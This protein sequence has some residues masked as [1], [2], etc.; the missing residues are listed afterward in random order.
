MDQDRCKFSMGG[1]I[2]FLFWLFVSMFTFPAWAKTA[3]RLEAKAGDSEMI[4]PGIVVEE[5][6]TNPS[7][8]KPMLQEGDI[9][10]S[11]SRGDAHGEFESP[12]SFWWLYTEQRPLGIVS[13]Q[14]L[15][16]GEAKTWILGSNE[17]NIRVRPNFTGRGLAKYEQARGL[18]KAGKVTQ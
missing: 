9:L 10:L 18:A 8:Q 13:V 11:W 12:F 2:L 5:V 6:K 17:F 1:T 3:D 4:L 7:P 15:R 14:G 16:R